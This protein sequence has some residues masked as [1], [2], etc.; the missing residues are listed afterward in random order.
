[1]QC[2]LETRCPLLTLDRH[3][4]RLAETLGIR[5]MEPA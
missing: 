2:S 1:L 5:F 3:M 4:K